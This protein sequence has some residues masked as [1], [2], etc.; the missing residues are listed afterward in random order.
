MIVCTRSTTPGRPTNHS[1][2][3]ATPN[4]LARPR[5]P[6]HSRNAPEGIYESFRY[7]SRRGTR[8]ADGTYLPRKIGR[9]PQTVHAARRR[10]DPDPHH[11]EVRRLS[12][13]IRGCG[14]PPAR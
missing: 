10:T 2:H 12:F 14:S 11:T 13:R 5:I 1:S 6:A 3:R 7:T 9:Q 8:N 4:I